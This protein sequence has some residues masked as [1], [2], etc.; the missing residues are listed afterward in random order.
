M[1]ENIIN[2]KDNKHKKAKKGLYLIVLITIGIL[3]ILIVASLLIDSIEKNANPDREINYNFYPADFNENI[4]DDTEYVELIAAEFLKFCDQTNGL[5]VG[6]TRENAKEQGIEVEFLVEMIYDIINGDNQSYN[7]RFSDTYYK[8]N[9]PKDKFTMQ[10]IYDVTI[11]YVSSEDISD[12][13]TGNY[14]KSVY[15]IEYK[16]FENNGT[17]R[18]DIGAGS[19]K[20]YFTISDASGKLLIDAVATV[21]Y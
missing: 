17:F 16:I 3:I 6:I 11:T 18:R 7:D 1:D 13:Q 5:T 12:E 10:K 19:K 15:S 20:Q 14:T 21:N 4:F 2:D 8:N 9:S